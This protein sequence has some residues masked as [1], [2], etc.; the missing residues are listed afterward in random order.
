MGAKDNNKWEA[1]AIIKA[2]LPNVVAT[3]HIWLWL[4]KLKFIG[5]STIQGLNSYTY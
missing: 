3:S 2:V 1:R 4:Y 5:N